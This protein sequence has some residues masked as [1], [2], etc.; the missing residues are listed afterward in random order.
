MM[1][2]L[3]PVGSVMVMFMGVG[4]GWRL[5]HLHG[6]S[7][8]RFILMLLYLLEVPLKRRLPGTDL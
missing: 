3:M 6:S 4:L 5:L 7:V 2:V 1:M 8:V